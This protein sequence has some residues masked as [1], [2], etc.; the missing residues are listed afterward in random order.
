[1]DMGGAVTVANTTLYAPYKVATWADIPDAQKE[2]TG[3]WV[4]DYGGYM[5]IGYDSA[6]LPAITAFTDLNKP[7]YK[8]KV[9]LNGDPTAANAALNGVEMASLANGGS[10]DDIS[11][12]VEF[13]KE[14]KKKGNFSSIQ[15]TTATVKS[16]TTPVVFD[17]DYLQVG[18]TK[19][20]PTWKVFVPPNAVLGGY[21]NQAINKKAP[22]PAAAR[23][24]EEFLYS[25]EGQNL[26]LKGG[27][28]PVRMDAMTT[29]KTIDAA[30][31]ASLPEVGG[32]PVFQTQEQVA[33]ASKYLA[34]NWASAIK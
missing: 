14:L 6:K 7:D 3:L 17:W 4:N 15:A 24:W 18:H 2:S 25:D 31:A 19:D 32:E 10:L 26:W 20:V 22:H 21:Y 5:S 12:G 11:K 34:A 16:G 27:A 30:A 28:R 33:A 23:L 29:A 8:N 13:F 9:A 1:M